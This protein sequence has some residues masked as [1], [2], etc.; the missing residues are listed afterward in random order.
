MSPKPKKQLREPTTLGELD[1]LSRV[2]NEINDLKK[3]AWLVGMPAVIYIVIYVAEAGWGV[4]ALVTHGMEGFWSTWYFGPLTLVLI[5][6]N[7]LASRKYIKPPEIQKLEKSV[8]DFE[9]TFLEDAPA[10]PKS[11][12]RASA[13][14]SG[15]EK[16]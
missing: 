11:V 14:K 2:E 3:L 12:G 7:A 16:N 13:K 15:S 10:K 6:G 1:R 9:E 8:D 5:W 4:Y